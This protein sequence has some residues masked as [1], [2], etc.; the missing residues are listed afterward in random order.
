MHS[1]SSTDVSRLA[2]VQSFSLPKTAVESFLNSDEASIMISTNSTS[3]SL[4]KLYVRHTDFYHGHI[5][6]RFL[7]IN[8]L[9]YNKRVREFVTDS[10]TLGLQLVKYEEG[11]TQSRRWLSTESVSLWNTDRWIC[12]RGR[13]LQSEFVDAI[14]VLP[15]VD[16]IDYSYESPSNGTVRC[17]P[18]VEAY[19]ISVKCSYNTTLNV[20]CPGDTRERVF[21]QVSNPYRHS[22]ALYGA[23]D[24]LCR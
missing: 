9:Q 24:S 8:L 21:Y 20:S 5:L 11:F 1:D 16:A 19:N 2:S 22:T 6:V 14:I 4:G 3:G 12:Y 17:L 10:I 18:K 15:N 23:V 7:G 13:K